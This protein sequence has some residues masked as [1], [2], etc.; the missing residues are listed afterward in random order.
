M[1]MYSVTEFYWC[2][3]QIQKLTNSLQKL[4]ISSKDTRDCLTSEVNT[5]TVSFFLQELQPFIWL[6]SLIH[7]IFFSM[8]NISC[9][10]LIYNSLKGLLKSTILSTFILCFELSSLRDINNRDWQLIEI[11]RNP[12][13]PIVKCSQFKS[14]YLSNKQ[15][16]R[17]I[18][19]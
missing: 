13:V 17:K 1:Y 9:C 6:L 15:L 16:Y 12:T 11:S 19:S 4:Q 3:L 7:L 14:V 2:V 10:V 18:N 5:Y 8:L